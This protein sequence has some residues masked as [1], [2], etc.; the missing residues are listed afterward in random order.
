MTPVCCGQLFISHYRGSRL[1]RTPEYFSSIG[2]QFKIPLQSNCTPQRCDRHS[3]LIDIFTLS[4]FT[5]VDS[6]CPPLSSQKVDITLID[7]SL[8]MTRRTV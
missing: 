5:Q 2:R 3:H 8:E 6:T 1:R 7:P 4:E